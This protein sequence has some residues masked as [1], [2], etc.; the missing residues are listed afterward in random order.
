MF[1]MIPLT[2]LMQLPMKQLEEWGPDEDGGG[3]E[4]GVGGVG[5][6][7]GGAGITG[8]VRSRDVRHEHRVRCGDV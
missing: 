1:T 2:M 7:G 6:M 5:G 3:L 4:E 8:W